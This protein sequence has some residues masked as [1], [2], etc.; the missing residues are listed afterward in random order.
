M[1][2]S[3][4]KHPDTVV[5]TRSLSRAL[6]ISGSELRQRLPGPERVPHEVR[7]AP[8]IWF[9]VVFL[10][11]FRGVSKGMPRCGGVPLAFFFEARGAVV[12]L[13]SRETSNKACVWTGWGGALLFLG[14][15]TSCASKAR[16][17]CEG[18]P[19]AV[20][21][22]K[23]GTNRPTF[24]DKQKGGCLSSIT[25]CIPQLVSVGWNSRYL[26]LCPKGTS[27]HTHTKNI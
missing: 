17:G 12:G 13:V 7:G 10:F 18:K 16:L 27:P 25:G 1:F 20:K 19:S 9:R 11:S 4:E 26:G 5:S 6:A 23:D 3:F 8:A 2:E 21:R 24:Q 14:R 15:L 22:R